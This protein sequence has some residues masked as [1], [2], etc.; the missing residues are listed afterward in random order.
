M[1]WLTMLL[2]SIL[3]APVYMYLGAKWSGGYKNEKD[4]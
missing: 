4:I 2:G 3:S 1:F